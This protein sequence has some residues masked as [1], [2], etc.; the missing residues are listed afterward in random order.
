M[1]SAHISKYK[2]KHPKALIDGEVDSF[3]IVINYNFPYRYVQ[4]ESYC[5][6]A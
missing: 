1:S 2:N 4:L 5:H 6:N 3:T